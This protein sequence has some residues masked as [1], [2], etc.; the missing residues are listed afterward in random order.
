[1]LKSALIRLSKRTRILL[2]TSL[3][4]F[5]TGVILFFLFFEGVLIWNQPSRSDYPIR[6]VDVSS[7]QGKIDWD[8]LASED[9]DF[10]FIKAT[11]GSTYTDRCFEDNWKGA[12]D[13]DLRV[14]AY[15][16]FSYDSSGAAQAAHFIATVPKVEGMLPPVVDVE[17]YGDYFDKPANAE[18]VLPELT[19]LLVALE[20]HYGMSPIIY[21]T[22]QAYNLYIA[23]RFSDNDIW[24]RDI[25]SK[26]T[27]SDGRSPAFWQ[28]TN[29]EKL[30]GYE[31]KERFI[32][33]NVFC[34]SEEDF[35]SYP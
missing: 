28:Y 27:L 10:A 29:R 22:E 24:F 4:L 11:E 33:M 35:L 7:Y 8:V 1:M 6:G 15:H 13:T 30:D 34:G 21:V 32:D 20:E 18:I 14:G 5:L 25:W 9:I 16:F 23:G 31:G 19:D 17:F 26:P 2:I 3:A 12:I